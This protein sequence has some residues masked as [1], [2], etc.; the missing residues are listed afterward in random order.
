MY[1]VTS[2]R[3]RASIQ[4]HGLDLERTETAL[5]ARV[6]AGLARSSAKAQL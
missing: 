2:S 6:R 1:H 4:E 3:N 5:S